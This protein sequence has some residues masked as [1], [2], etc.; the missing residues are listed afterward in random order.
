MDDPR[1]E[2]SGIGADGTTYIITGEISGVPVT[3]ES[4]YVYAKGSLIN[5]RTTF[6]AATL[7][8]DSTRVDEVA[9]ITTSSVVYKVD[10]DC[11]VSANDQTIGIC[12]DVLEI[13]G[14]SFS[15]ATTMS[16]SYDLN[17]VVLATA[18]SSARIS[19]HAAFLSTMPVFFLVFGFL[20][21][22]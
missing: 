18:K 4:L 19:C 6:R 3:G 17:P 13:V 7:V 2:I 9:A 11:S 10:V 15:T 12:T 5:V 22:A 21:Y 20:L 8:E 16:G 1:G 14:P